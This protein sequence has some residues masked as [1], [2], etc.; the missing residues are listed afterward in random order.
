MLTQSQ[1]NRYI[2]DIEPWRMVKNY[3]LDPEE[4]RIMVDWCIYNCMEALRI[5]SIALQPIM[6]E[7][8]T[9]LLD[10]MKVRP[11]R[12]MFSWA[13]RGADDDYGLEAT[14]SKGRAKQGDTI[15]PP[16]IAPDKPDKELEKLLPYITESTN[17]TNK[18]ST[19]LAMEA[20]LGKQGLEKLLKTRM[21]EAEALREKD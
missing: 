3:D 16:V 1:T 21:K 12:R 18:M 10:G 17:K 11:D 8:A 14:V 6:P 15:F 2:S 13:K 19:Y 7:K 9:R 20:R 5:A 4:K